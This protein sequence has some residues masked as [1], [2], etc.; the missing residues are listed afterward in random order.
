MLERFTSAV[1][2]TERA[3][4]LLKRSGLGIFHRTTEQMREQQVRF[5]LTLKKQVPRSLRPLGM[6]TLWI[7]RNDNFVGRDELRGFP[8]HYDSFRKIFLPL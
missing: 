6:T 1:E 3:R 8:L 2:G 5:D 4:V 7:D